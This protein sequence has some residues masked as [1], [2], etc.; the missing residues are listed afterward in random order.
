MFAGKARKFARSEAYLS[1]AAT[2]KDAALAQHADF[3]QSRQFY[4]SL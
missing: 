3:L 2:T 1:Y 4:N